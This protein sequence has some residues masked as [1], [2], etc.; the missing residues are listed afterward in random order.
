MPP[1]INT[2]KV[3]LAVKSIT[4]VL[5]SLVVFFFP[6]VDMKRTRGYEDIYNVVMQ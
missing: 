6:M 2:R 3:F 4:L 5:E 1:V